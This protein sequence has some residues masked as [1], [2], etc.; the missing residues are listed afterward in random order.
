MHLAHT[1]GSK[2]RLQVVQLKDLAGTEQSAGPW[3]GFPR[4]HVSDSARF[5]VLKSRLSFSVVSFTLQIAIFCPPF[6]WPESCQP[7]PHWFTHLVPCLT[8]N[9][10][11]LFP[12]FHP[13]VP[14]PHRWLTRSLF[15]NL[16]SYSG[17]L[18]QLLSLIPRIPLG[19]RHVPSKA[20]TRAL[21]DD[22][23]SQVPRKTHPAMGHGL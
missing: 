2:Q 10:G 23:S 18:L 1:A 6:Y 11:L 14:D 20:K 15:H 21:K 5:D 4:S 13:V 22:D 12:T 7:R 19:C 3:C 8:S 9:L 16:Y 17:S